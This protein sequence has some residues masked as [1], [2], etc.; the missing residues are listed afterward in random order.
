MQEPVLT[1]NFFLTIMLVPGL[2]ALLG[3]WINRWIKGLDRSIMA[4]DLKMT[5]YCSENRKEHDDIWD[6]MYHHE[7]MNDGSV[8]IPRKE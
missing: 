7:H 3:Y 2:I 1:W 4:L 8:V 5:G 6:R